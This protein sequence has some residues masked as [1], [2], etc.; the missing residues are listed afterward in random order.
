MDIAFVEEL[1]ANRLPGSS[2]EEHIVGPLCAERT[3]LSGLRKGTSW[4]FGSARMHL[5]EAVQMPREQVRRPRGGSLFTVGY[6]GRTLDDLIRVLDIHRVS[7][8]VDVRENAVSRKAGF[9]KRSLQMALEEAGI[10]YRHEPLLGNPRDNRQGFRRGL[11]KAREHYTKHLNNGSRKAFEA[12]VEVA[13]NQRVALLCFERNES[14]CH[15]GCIVEQAQ[16]EVPALS[17][18]AL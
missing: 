14:D 9:G 17:S 7:I 5:W 8:L 11:A 6:E 13:L 16:H 15:R 12:L 4:L 18:I 2:L 1:A 10:E 3:S